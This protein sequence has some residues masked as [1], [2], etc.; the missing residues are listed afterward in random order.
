MHAEDGE[1]GTMKDNQ[2]MIGATCTGCGKGSNVGR[3]GIVKQ[4][5]LGSADKWH[6]TCY[7]NRNRASVDEIYIPKCSVH[8]W[9][10]KNTPDRDF[11]QY[12]ADIHNRDQHG[13]TKSPNRKWM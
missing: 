6:A 13:S 11:A 7:R 4:R 5:D 2:R 8:D 12:Q 1:E 10:G 9:E 3:Y